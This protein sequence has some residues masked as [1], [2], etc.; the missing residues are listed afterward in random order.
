MDVFVDT[1]YLMPF[2]YLDI[3]VDGF[4]RERFREKLSGFRRI[5]VS[6]ISIVEVKAKIVRMKDRKINEVFRESLSILR[7]DERFVF[8]GYTA[9]DDARFEET[10]EMSLD[11]IDRIIVSQA[12]SVGFLL[13][14]DRQILKNK[15]S[16]KKLGLDVV[17]WKEFVEF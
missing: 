12:F 5:H 13:T 9:D 6:E 3:G 16:L 17:N 2:F 14:E 15:D 10:E 1:T 8:H 7:Y 4:S 11:F